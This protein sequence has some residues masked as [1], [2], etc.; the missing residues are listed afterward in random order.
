MGA[1]LIHEDARRI[2]L[3]NCGTPATRSKVEYHIWLNEFKLKFYTKYPLYKGVEQAADLEGYKRLIAEGQKLL[4]KIE[5]D[6]TK[7]HSRI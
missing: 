1:G 7:N 4:K 2:T 6:E 5:R 3:N